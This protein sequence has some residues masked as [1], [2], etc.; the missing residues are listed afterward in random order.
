MSPRTASL[1]LALALSGAGLGHAADGDAD[2]GF[3]TDAE[4]PGYG[5]YLNPMSQGELDESVAV[6]AAADG[7]LYYFGNFDDGQ[8]GNRAAIWRLDADGYF[9]YDFGEAGL[10]TLVPPCPNG[11]LTHATLDVQGRPLLAFSGC[12][13][14][15]IYRLTPE[16]APDTSLLG[17]GRLTIAFNMGGSNNDRP[18]RIASTRAGGI[19]VAGSVANDD[20]GDLGIAH[21]TADGGAAP[22]FGNAGRVTLPFTWSVT[23]VTGVYPMHDGRIVAAGDTQQNPFAITQFAVRVQ[24]NGAPDLGFGNS[25]PGI[26]EVNM[27]TLTGHDGG[28]SITRTSLLEPTGSIVQAGIFYEVG[29]E[30]AGSQMF[31]MRWREDGELDTTLGPF[32]YRVYGLDLGGAGNNSDGVDAIARQGDGKYVLAGYSYNSNGRTELSMLRLRRDFSLDPQFGDGG[33]LHELVAIAQNGFPWMSADQLLLRP[34][35]IITSLLIGTGPGNLM[36]LRAATNDQL[37]A[38]TFD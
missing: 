27:R 33:T 25:A 20:M 1:L 36:S 14:F 7:R 10:R 29:D 35:R 11:W 4:F 28:G 9:D 8:G 15:E 13:D 37:F 3:G 30:S 12:G 18:M 5:F 2:A 22:G 34:G 21:F 38:D 26:S 17:S 6:A 24:P 32:G 19:V 23:R 31:V 16:G